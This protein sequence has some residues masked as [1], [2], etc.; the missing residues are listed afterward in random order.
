MSSAMPAAGA[1]YGFARRAMGKVGGALTGFGYNESSRLLSLCYKEDGVYYISAARLDTDNTLEYIGTPVESE[2][3]LAL[4]ASYGET[5]YY[6]ETSSGKTQI[7]CADATSG[8]GRLV[9]SFSSVSVLCDTI[10][11]VRFSSMISSCIFL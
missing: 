7:Y 6:T 3:K 1:G 5:I 10:T 8:S 4:V 2:D 11:T 9:H